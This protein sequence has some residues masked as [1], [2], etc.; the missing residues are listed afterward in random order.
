MRD[1]RGLLLTVVL[2]VIA[3]GAGAWAGARWTVERQASAGSLHAMVHDG[4]SLTSAQDQRLDAIERRFASR[5]AALEADL[6][7]AN[8]EL[9]AAIRSSQ[10]DS[11]QVQA[12]IDHLHQA[13]GA[14]QKETVRH[15]FEM[16][17]VLTPAQAEIF[18]RR[19]AA[20]LTQGPQ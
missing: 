1:L 12:A 19:V 2:A 16:R 11:P 20:S 6:R 17:A 14:L 8:A 18:D 9:A 13:M 10:G 3:A 7:A 5:R 15:V 4:L